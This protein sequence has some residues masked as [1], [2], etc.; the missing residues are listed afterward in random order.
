MLF[1]APN[2]ISV[3]EST[4]G[5]PYLYGG[6]QPFN[7]GADCSGD[8][9]FC[10]QQCVDAQGHPIVFPR[11]TDAEWDDL[12]HVADPTL[13][14]IQPGY[15]VEFEVPGDGGSPPQH[16]GVYL[17]PNTMVDDPETGMVVSVQQIPYIPGVIW[18]IGYVIPPFVT[19]PPPP[20]APLW[21]GVNMQCQDPDTGGIWVI[22]P[23]NGAVY[24]YSVNGSPTPPYLGGFN[25]HP[26]WDVDL[27][28]LAGFSSFG[29]AGTH[30]YVASFLNAAGTGYNTY[31]FT[32]DGRFAKPTGAAA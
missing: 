17:G 30:G 27:F 9:Q 21:E 23:T 20:P 7:G 14:G 31:G 24:A 2:F 1:T 3:M 15:L 28:R 11:N 4:E 26:D 8:I 13:A 19:G 5:T 25:I 22:N 12:V 16:V 18:P 10:A 6:N 32:R 29:N